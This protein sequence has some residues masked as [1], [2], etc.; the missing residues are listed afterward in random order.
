MMILINDMVYLISDNCFSWLA[1]IVSP[2][3]K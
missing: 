1:T 3:L 2:Y